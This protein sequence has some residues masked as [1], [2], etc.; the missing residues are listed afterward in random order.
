MPESTFKSGADRLILIDLAD[1]QE[2]RH[3]VGPAG[4]EARP[5]GAPAHAAEGLA[6]HDGPGGAPV[7][8]EIAGAHAL[9]PLLLLAVVEALQSRRQPVAGLVDEIDGLV[10]VAC[11]HDAEE[12][13]EELRRVGD[14]AGRDAPLDSR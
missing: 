5:H 14:A 7:H 6:Q 4:L 3:V 9:R 1:A 8:V 11:D 12:R 10:E 2:R 13:T